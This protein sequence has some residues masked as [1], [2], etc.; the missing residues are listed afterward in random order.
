MF[1]FAL[2][3]SMW[4]QAA[5]WASDES[6]LEADTHVAFRG[7]FET[8]TSE[9]RLLILGASEYLA[10]LDGMLIHDGPARFASGFP[11]YQTVIL[12]AAPGRHV[13]AVQVR[14]DGVTTRM[15]SAYRP[16]LWCQIQ[17]RDG[18][19]DITWKCAKM[20]G[21]RP[22][23]ARI[24]DILGWID[25]CDTRQAW[26]DWQKPGFDDATWGEPVTTPLPEGEMKQAGTRPVRMD[27]I[28]LA[29][30]ARGKW[31]G[32]YGYEADDPAV[33]FFLDD[34]DP[35]DVPAQGVWFRYDL[36]RTRL[37]RPMIT[38]NAPAGTVVE[39][40]LSEQ[41]RQGKVH[42]WITLSGSRSCNMDHFVARGGRQE[43]M[44]MTPKGGRYLEVHIQ[45]TK[46]TVE[47]AAFLERT[48]FGPATGSFTS[49]DKLLDQIWKTGVDTVHACADDALVDCPTRERGQWTG[50]VASVAT[51]IVAAAFG[52]LSLSRRALVQ[53]AQAARGDGLV[54]GV[55][56]GDPGYLSTYAAQWVNACVR[57]WE[58]TGDR[59]LLVELAPAARR[60]IQAFEAKRTADGVSDDLGWGFVDWGYVH[61]AGPTDMGLNLHYLNALRAMIRW[62]KEVGGDT[63]P[64]LAAEK[65]VENLIR[66]WLQKT[67]ADGGWAAAGYQRAAL[68]LQAK[69]VPAK[70]VKECIAAL[71]AHLLSCYP[72]DPKGP[73]LSDPGVSDPRVMTPYFCHFAFTALLENGEADFVLGQ[74]RKCWGWALKQ[75]YTTWPEVFDP[76]W[77]LCHEW[78]GCPTWQLTHYVLGLQ[79]RFDLGTDT[80]V[81][82][83]L[84]G[85]LSKAAGAYPLPGG[86]TVKVK[87]QKA[88]GGLHVE[89]QAP[90]AINIR[91]GTEAYSFEGSKSFVVQ[92]R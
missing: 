82:D 81:F 27:E 36:G 64:Y 8:R 43:L 87:W 17:E 77:S 25:W 89:F 85:G 37:G 86:G 79:P 2:P 60:N 51:E 39:M 48:Y 68:A 44:P 61:N 21:Y 1:G 62:E 11:E 46:A 12:K 18:T 13:L 75:G 32:S 73:R 28:A 67:L 6:T 5:I 83:P 65:Q 7:S 47:K 24:S 90:R 23:A 45:S 92:S 4:N 26:A 59:S 40:A 29:P 72:N 38:L 66:T 3:P 78:S 33:R 69:L 58:L 22:R 42:P 53:A 63:K 14:N 49:G 74:Y 76:R 41:L 52:D 80:F 16:F 30:I 55:G 91:I 19:R 50:D 57:Y 35:K 20:P 31:A 88:A 84:P 56:P 9:P 70:D 34:L 10:W 71:E 15:L 54:A